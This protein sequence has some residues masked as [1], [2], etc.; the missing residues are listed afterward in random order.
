M[1]EP[2]ERVEAQPQ[3][4]PVREARRRYV[5]E[6][7]PFEIRANPEIRQPRPKGTTNESRALEIFEHSDLA[8][9]YGEA[10]VQEKIIE[11]HK[12]L[13]GGITS[14][15][16]FAQRDTPGGMTLSHV[17]MGSQFPHLS[18]QSSPGRG[19]PLLR[20][21]GRSFPRPAQAACR[22]RRLP[23]ERH[24]VQVQG[25]ARRRRSARI[26][27]WRR[28]SERS[29]PEA[30]GALA[31][32]P[33]AAH[34]RRQGTP[35]RMGSARTDRRYGIGPGGDGCGRRIASWF[36]GRRCRDYA[37]THRNNRVPSMA[38]PQ[39]QPVEQPR[40][41]P[42]I[43][44][45][46]ER[47]PFEIRANPTLNQPR[48]RGTVD[49]ARVRE[50]YEQSP[51]AEKYGK[52]GEEKMIEMA[53]ATAGGITST[54]LF[55]QDA[56]NGMRLSHV[57]MGPTTS[58]PAT[59][60]RNLG[61]AS[62]AWSPVKST[63]ARADW[64]LAPSSSC[65]KACRTSS[66]RDLP[67][68]RCSSIEPTATVTKM[69]PSSNSRRTPSTRSSRS[70]T[71]GRHTSTSG[72]PPSG[73][74]IRQYDRQRWMGEPNSMAESHERLEERNHRKPIREPDRKRRQRYV[75][76]RGPFEISANPLSIHPV[77]PKRLTTSTAPVFSNTAP[78]RKSAGK[79]QSGRR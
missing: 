32:L 14:T 27:R 66:G 18:S 54:R 56:P 52:A 59:V 67:A 78:L 51:L 28:R 48:A 41:K 4:K 21:R 8:E 7:G 46:S 63:W 24:A 2:Q 69:L 60:I 53:H 64:G 62:T 75:S 39:E 34:R 58:Y 70:S 15:S 19:L 79:R 17:W 71:R 37:H 29:R 36:A 20:G 26:P 3:K 1:A 55:D 5:S 44:Y 25:R 10:P 6:R 38:E 33:P 35:A 40:K 9:K 42:R 65:R 61:T 74:A 45:V 49:R 16:L 11:M 30:R 72:K 23:A 43:R 31:G 50:N 13:A 73:A 47:G 76:E 57:W 22:F 12:A 77:H 68:P